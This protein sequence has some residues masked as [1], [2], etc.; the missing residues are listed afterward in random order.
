[1]LITTRIKVLKIIEFFRIILIEFRL[2][3][4]VPEFST[5]S[6]IRQTDTTQP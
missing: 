1:M 3:D 5:V 2:P 6:T 4:G